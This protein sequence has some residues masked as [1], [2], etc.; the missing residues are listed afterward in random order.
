MP[1]AVNIGTCLAI[2]A[3]RRKENSELFQDLLADAIG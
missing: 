3:G 1:I 2:I